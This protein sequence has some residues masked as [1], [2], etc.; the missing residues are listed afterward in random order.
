[1]ESLEHENEELKRQLKSGGRDRVVE[2]YV[3]DPNAVKRYE[4]EIESLRNEIESLR[5]K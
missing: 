5:Q 1:L 2:T 3:A 4:R